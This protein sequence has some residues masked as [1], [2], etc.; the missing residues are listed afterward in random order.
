MELC[1]IGNPENRR[2]TG[3]QQAF[4]DLTGWPPPCL[5]YAE[6]IREPALL[7]EWRPE[8]IRIE[9]PGE[10]DETR[11]LLI[12]LGGGPEAVRMEFGEIAWLREFHLGYCEVLRWIESAGTPTMNA[13]GDIAGMFDKWHC[14]QRFIRRDVNRPAA[15]LA[16]RAVSELHELMRQRGAG[17]IF[18]KPLHGSSASGVC[19]FRW[20][21]QRQ[22]LIAP[23]QIKTLRGE[24]TLFNSL[25]VCTYSSWNEIEL[26]LGKLLPQGMISE[27]WIPKLSISGG[28][29]DLRVLV[30]AGEARHWLVRQSATPMTNLHLGNRRGDKIALEAEIGS[31]R[32]EACFELAV[33]AARC[34]G[35][36]LYAGVDILIDTRGC[37]LLVGEINAFGDLLPNLL[38]RG[39]S[40]YS[41]IASAWRKSRCTPKKQLRGVQ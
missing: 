8:A 40:T 2:V 35:S 38:H 3:F 33:K 39:E 10:N 5:S 24:P 22:Q 1:I 11:N 30:I 13:P 4:S 21:P 7:R 18:L 14:H 27:E 26:I 28:V 9:S 36:S 20:T 23:I 31:A 34:F 32:L 37:R 25:R 29:V 16:P 6:F 15:E 19:A 17:R 41:A 12:A